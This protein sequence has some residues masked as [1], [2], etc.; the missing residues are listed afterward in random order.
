MP[1][2]FAD[3]RAEILRV[4]AADSAGR[5]I[6]K[7]CSRFHQDSTRGYLDDPSPITIP[8]ER[9]E[10]VTV[11]H[12]LWRVT[13]RQEG[14]DTFV[15]KGDDYWCSSEDGGDGVLGGLNPFGRYP[16]LRTQPNGPVE[17][18]SAADIPSE[19]GA[20]VS[21]YRTSLSVLGAGTASYHFD[22]DCVSAAGIT[23]DTAFVPV[24]AHVIELRG[25]P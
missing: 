11:E 23:D 7:G 10:E 2:P 18:R 9:G 13:K 24:A 4:E 14:R 5:V 6:A 17:L 25:A 19:S 15:D 16:C 22:L 3:Q 8:A 1:E 12:R 20:V 21:G